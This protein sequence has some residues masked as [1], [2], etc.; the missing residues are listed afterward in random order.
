MTFVT[1]RLLSVDLILSLISF[2]NQGVRG[3]GYIGGDNGDKTPRPLQH[4]AVRVTTA[5]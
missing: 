5:W 3:Y 4:K 2:Y 1:K